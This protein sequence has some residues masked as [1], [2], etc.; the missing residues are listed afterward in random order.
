MFNIEDDKMSKEFT[1]LIDR[2]T[3]KQLYEM[4][5]VINRAAGAG[6]GDASVFV[7]GLSNSEMQIAQQQF[8]IIDSVFATSPMGESAFTS[9][10]NTVSLSADVATDYGAEQTIASLI[11]GE[12]LLLVVANS[13]DMDR[14]TS[15]VV[16]KYIADKLKIYMINSEDSQWYSNPSYHG[17]LLSA[18]IRDTKEKKQMNL[19]SQFD[20]MQP[21]GAYSATTSHIFKLTIE[22]HG[23]NNG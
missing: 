18:S 19:S 20:A 17:S 11:D 16:A 9:S 7:T 12:F 6:Y 21:D 10:A 23:E 8:T 13:D 3:P 5:R 1:V 2:A 14:L 4:G 22:K 15:S